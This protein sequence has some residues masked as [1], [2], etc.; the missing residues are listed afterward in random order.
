MAA[1]DLGSSIELILKEDPNISLNALD[2]RLNGAPPKLKKGKKPKKEW[3]MYPRS[4]IAAELKRLRPAK[5]KQLVANPK[6]IPLETLEIERFH[7]NAEIASYMGDIQRYSEKYFVSDYYY[8]VRKLHADK[9]IELL[10]KLK[11]LILN[12]QEH[13]SDAKEVIAELQNQEKNLEEIDQMI[14]REWEKLERT[15]AGQA[16]RDDVTLKELTKMQLQA[17]FTHFVL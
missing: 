9:G 14:E 13:G 17:S 3:R 15:D 4:S 2:K 5:K 16:I 8:A 1:A 10:G 11:I 6:P 7:L 12:F